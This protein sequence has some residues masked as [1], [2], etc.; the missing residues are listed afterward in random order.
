MYIGI[1]NYKISACN[2]AGSDISLS[3]SKQDDSALE[4]KWDALFDTVLDI[5]LDLSKTCYIGALDIKLNDSSVKKAEILVDGIA[6]GERHAESG[7]LIGGNLI[8]PIGVYGSEVTIRLHADF[9][10]IIL[11]AP[12]I[13]G[14]Y[15]DGAP[16][17]IPSP[18]KRNFV[19]RYIR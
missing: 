16:V 19:T 2:I 7:K 10:D 9:Q 18:K 8:I 6:S 17:I 14:A 1:L 4:W 11:S 12:E 5:K 13:V 3:P 15:D